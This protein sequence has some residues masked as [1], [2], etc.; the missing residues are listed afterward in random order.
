MIGRL[1]PQLS[2]SRKAALSY[3][4]LRAITRDR[5]VHLIVLKD[6]GN[7]VGTG[8]LVLM[9]TILGIRAR[10]E[11]VIVDAAYRRRGLGGRLVRCLIAIAKKKKARNIELSSR[12]ERIAAHK[13]YLKHGFKEKETNIYVLKL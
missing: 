8:T 1:V 2:S 12:A 13:L 11:D 9:P 3:A 10:I 6:G 5:N 7:I 4:A